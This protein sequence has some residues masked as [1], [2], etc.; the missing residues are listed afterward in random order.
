MKF[1]AFFFTRNQINALCHKRNLL[2]FTSTNC[3]ILLIIAGIISILFMTLR[4]T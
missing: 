2:I 3:L 4:F 1:K